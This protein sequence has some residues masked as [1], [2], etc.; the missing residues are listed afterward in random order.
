[1]FFTSRFRFAEENPVMKFEVSHTFDADIDAVEKAIFDPA[2]PAFLLK[3]M[4]LVTI[5]EPLDRQEDASSI[6]RKTKYQPVPLIK[7]IG[8]KE[9]PP[10]WMAWIEESTYDRRAR[11]MDFVNIPTT[12]K[13]RNLLE[14]KGSLTLTAAGPGKTKR[15]MNGELKVK[16][17]LLGKIAE[18]MIYKQAAQILD[19]EAAALRKFIAGSR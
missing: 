5:I 9:V 17:F 4:K 10:H 13:I 6:R 12:E 1:M 7:K 18:G 16:V 3:E 19:E 8:P 2:L 15:T 14:N 11:R